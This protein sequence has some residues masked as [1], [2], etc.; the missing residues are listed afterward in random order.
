MDTFKGSFFTY[1]DFRDSLQGESP[2]PQ[3]WKG[4]DLAN[5]QRDMQPGDTD[6]VALSSESSIGG[7][8]ILPGTVISMQWLNPGSTLNQHA[9]TWWHLFIIQSGQ[10][11]LT[12]GDAQPVPVSAGDVIVVPAWNS[13]GFVN[14]SVDEALVMLNISNMPQVAALSNFADQNGRISKVR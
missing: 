5:L 10:G 2:R 9:H 3:V 4:A 13:H 1:Q 14:G 12:L 11:Q 7:C 8:E 6:I